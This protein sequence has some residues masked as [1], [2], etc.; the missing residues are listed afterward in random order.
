MVFHADDIEA[1]LRAL[2]SGGVILYPTDTIWGLGCDALNSAA[3]KNIYNIKQRTESK[4]MILGVDAVEMMKHYISPALF[5]ERP[6]EEML[7]KW[8]KPTTI[9]LEGAINLPPE[10]IA[11]DGSVAFRI[12]NE[13]FCLE[14]IKLHG[15]PIVSTSANLS[16]EAPPANFSA[17]G[18]TMLSSVDYVVRYRQLDTRIAKPSKIVRLNTKGEIIVIRE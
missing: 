2:R 6:I 1:A 8:D 9:I 15:R 14:L 17:I 12:L 7:G 4:S 16:G 11:E 3:I 5:D 13:P 18:A 10:L